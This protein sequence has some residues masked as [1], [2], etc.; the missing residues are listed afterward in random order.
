MSKKEDLMKLK[1]DLEALQPELEAD[2]A[3]AIEKWYGAYK[4]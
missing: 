3:E 4:G 1:A 2:N